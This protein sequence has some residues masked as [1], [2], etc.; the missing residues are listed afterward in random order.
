MLTTP[1]L[2]VQV[3][4]RGIRP[5]LVDP[6]DP[7]LRERAARIGDIF[8]QALAGRWTRGQLEARLRELE[9]LEV[10]HRLTRGLAKVMW[11][12]SELATVAPLD[13]V[14]IRQRV[15]AHAAATGPLARR[16]GP[17][18][19]RVA[20]DVIAEVA[21]D[22]GVAPDEVSASL[23]ADLREEQ[24]I[25]DCRPLPPDRLLHRYNVAQVQAILLRAAWMKV[26]LVAPRPKRVA[27]L[28]RF[29]RFHQLMYRVETVAGG[30]AVLL[31]LDGPESLLRQS[32]RYGMQLA[33]F[34]PAVLLQEGAWTVEAEVLWGR[35]RLAKKLLITH[36]WGLRSHYRDTGVWRSRTEEWFEERWGE[37]QQG[38]IRHPG[39]LQVV[40]GQ[41]IIVPTWT[42][43]KQ[44]R[45]AHLDVVGFW[46]RSY[47]QQ[48]IE[49][50][51][52]DVGLAVSRRLCGDKE[53]LPD[54]LRDRVIDFAEVIP[55][56]RVV[57]L[58]ER[59]AR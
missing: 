36:E 5:R 6:E 35:R 15:F 42:F 32:S 19:R 20:A 54:A 59:I 4:G 18:G 41:H 34:F 12:R 2:R 21:A 39:E 48:R 13:P 33:T 44:G 58:L 28:L 31:H 10:D 55:V 25:V 38:W 40:E 17:T 46:R 51:P 1:L 47:L 57:D 50:T 9:G 3:R 53:G 22:L 30:A 14:E 11:D 16:P 27:Q 24:R 26:R 23:Y 45:T 52:A 43:R 29:A 37:D 56:D 49:R 7:A 8:E